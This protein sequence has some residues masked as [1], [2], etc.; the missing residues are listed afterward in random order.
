MDYRIFIMNARRD[1]MAGGYDVA[2]I[3][4]KMQMPAAPAQPAA[5]HPQQQ[6]KTL[7]P[8][9]VPRT[10]D[11]GE[12]PCSRVVQEFSQVFHVFPRFVQGL[13]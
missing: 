6:A 10:S 13:L 12:A 4:A 2:Y 1:Y 9:L 5:A 7:M 3:D 8:S 11:A